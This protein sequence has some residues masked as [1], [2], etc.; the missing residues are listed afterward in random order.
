[1]YTV[2]A[3]KSENIKEIKCF[4]LFFTNDFLNLSIFYLLALEQPHT[5]AVSKTSHLKMPR[6]RGKW[7][8]ILF[9]ILVRWVVTTK[10]KTR[11]LIRIKQATAHRNETYLTDSFLVH[12]PYASF[13]KTIQQLPEWQSSNLLQQFKKAPPMALSLEG[14]GRQYSDMIKEREGG[15]K[16]FN[17]G[18]GSDR[19]QQHQDQTRRKSE[20]SVINHLRTKA[21]RSKETRRGNRETHNLPTWNCLVIGI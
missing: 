10:H 12:V 8:S 1:M 17:G 4:V 9:S 19:R 7:G 16:N 5:Y 13:P 11:R 6:D 15:R 3:F 21:P 20:G 18:V 2:F 14:W